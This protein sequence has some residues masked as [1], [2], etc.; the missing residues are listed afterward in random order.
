MKIINYSKNNN[1]PQVYNPYFAALKFKKFGTSRLFEDFSVK[2]N[3]GKN[4]EDC[5][6]RAKVDDA[7]FLFNVQNKKGISL[8]KC[9]SNTNWVD[10]VLYNSTIENLD[11]KHSLKGVGSV[12]HLG[13]IIVLLEN[14]KF[15]S[16]NLFSLGSSV[17]FH[18]KLKFKPDI[19]Y[20]EELVSN[21]KEIL[22]HSDDKR[23]SK[24]IQE[25]KKFLKYSTSEIK[26]NINEGNAIL[27]RYIQ[28]VLANKLHKDENFS[29]NS[30]FEMM[31]TKKD[32]IEN[33]DYYNS[34]FKKYGID[35]QI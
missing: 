5:F 23:F 2:L 29:F 30:G 33:K 28:N 27:D 31:L 6:V 35:Y 34:L 25:A 22:R 15:D 3:S 9:S 7:W 4:T 18:A 17:F 20:Y 1:Y 24:N 11:S 16:I 13:Q 10:S 21:L 8:G 26:T 12:M 32:V 19:T 14:P